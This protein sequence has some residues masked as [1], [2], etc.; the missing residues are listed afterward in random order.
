LKRSCRNRAI[1]LVFNEEALKKAELSAIALIDDIVQMSYG[2]PLSHSPSSTC[3]VL[4]LRQL[5]EFS[6]GT[7][8]F[9]DGDEGGVEASA[10][11]GF[12]FLAQILQSSWPPSSC[13][14]H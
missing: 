4:K 12:L 1:L 7:A 13:H 11:E 6:L 2:L 10:T 5:Q 8:W 14:M 3:E 9:R